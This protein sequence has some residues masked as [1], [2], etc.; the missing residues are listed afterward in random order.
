M[1]TNDCLY[2]LTIAETRS[3]SKAAE[4]LYISQPYISR[5]ASNFEKRLGTK[6][7]DRSK[8]P[9]RLTE[10]GI[11]FL[12]Y[13]CKFI[14]LENEVYRNLKVG[15]NDLNTFSIGTSELTGTYILP[16]VTTQVLEKYPN[17]QTKI[18]EKS[19]I[20]LEKMVRN[21]QLNMAFVC[22]SNYHPELNY[23]VV[24]KCRVIMVVPPRNKL[25][26][27]DR[28]NR[29]NIASFNNKDLKGLKFLA[30]NMT[31]AINQMSIQYLEDNE[32]SMN[33]LIEKGTVE[34][35]LKDCINE[36]KIAFVPDVGIS[37]SISGKISNYYYIGEQYSVNV[38]AV[39]KQICQ[40]IQDA[41]KW[42]RE[43]WDNFSCFPK[44]E[45][46]LI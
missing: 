9:I 24:Y 30:P 14:E 3:F 4:Q 16:I 25:Y 11:I 7:F 20:E 18:I 42:A 43:L 22:F 45:N 31:P 44:E 23:D 41:I 10:N 33:N 5:W 39:Y 35:T 21:D 32:L 46:D 28:C 36:N 15:K 17:I 19:S 34:Q 37:Y 8:Y 1:N 27:E 13:A 6:L 2:F 26:I 12:E 29:I 38:I 40:E